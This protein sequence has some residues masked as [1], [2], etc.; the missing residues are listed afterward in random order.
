MCRISR[1]T[2]YIKY[3]FPENCSL[4]ETMKRNSAETERSKK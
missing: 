3:I 2:F 1:H 4:F